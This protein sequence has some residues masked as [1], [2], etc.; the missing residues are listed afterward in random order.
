MPKY[1]FCPQCGKPLVEEEKA[2]KV[3]KTC[4]DDA[5]GFIFWDNPLPVVAAIVE[6]KGHV[7]L[8]QS[9]GWPASWFG[10]V[11]GFLEKGEMPEEA[12]LREVQEEIGLEVEMGGYIGMYPFYRMNQ[13]IIA[14][15]VIAKDGEI[16]LD[17]TELAAYREVPIEKV[18]PW[19]AGTGIALRDWLRT[20]GYERE[21]VQFGS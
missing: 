8:V 20:K 17:E 3:R 19:A 14:D 2:E 1:N 16:K 21:L 5:C 12:V 10:L 13:L 7:I 15:H 4:A 18:Q 6:R 11:T 9:I